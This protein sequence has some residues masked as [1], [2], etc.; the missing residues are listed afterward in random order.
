[1]TDITDVMSDIKSSE[2]YLKRMSGSERERAVVRKCSSKVVLGF[3]C[4]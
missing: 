1:V 2:L 3:H 4:L